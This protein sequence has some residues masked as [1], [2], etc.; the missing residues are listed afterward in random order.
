MDSGILLNA[1]ETG[2]SGIVDFVYIRLIDWKFCTCARAEIM[3]TCSHAPEECAYGKG[4]TICTPVA[5]LGRHQLAHTLRTLA[6]V[7]GAQNED[8][9]ISKQRW[10]RP[11]RT[12]SGQ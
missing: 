1:I 6:R 3:H 4:S 9:T 10:E 8:A 12:G 7:A 2:V 5:H 11:P